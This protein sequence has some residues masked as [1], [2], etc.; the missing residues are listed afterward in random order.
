M[1]DHH[2]DVYLITC[3]ILH[4]LISKQDKHLKYLEQFYFCVV[5]I[6]MILFIYSLG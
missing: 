2:F 5:W 1:S 4:L 3:K 6:K